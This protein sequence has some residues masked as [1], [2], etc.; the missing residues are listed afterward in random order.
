M[1]NNTSK[2]NSEVTVNSL[3]ISLINLFDRIKDTLCNIIDKN[4]E[5]GHLINE[6]LKNNNN[7]YYVYNNMKD[8]YIKYCK[9][10][11]N[12]CKF[13]NITKNNID[14]IIDYNYLTLL[15]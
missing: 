13:L 14:L 12:T 9:N 3:S 5:F 7:D 11:Q 1:N 15:N 8:Q 10:L 4:S 2:T 6:I